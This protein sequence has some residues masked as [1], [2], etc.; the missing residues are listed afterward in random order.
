M[1]SRFQ[2]HFC[3]TAGPSLH[4]ASRGP[5]SK[6]RLRAFD[7][8]VF[9]VLQPTLLDLV[10]V[11]GLY[12]KGNMYSILYTVFANWSSISD[13]LGGNLRSLN[14]YMFLDRCL[15]VC[16]DQALGLLEVG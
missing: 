5:L 14:G 1:F 6:A 12:T 13:S 9:R 11:R 10:C 8:V 7:L 4:D 16:P 3:S 2:E 15:A